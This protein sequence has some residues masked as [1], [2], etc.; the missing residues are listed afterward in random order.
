MRQIEYA[1]Q[2]RV[3]RLTTSSEFEERGLLMPIPLFSLEASDLATDSLGT[4]GGSA[5]HDL[6]VQ[7]RELVVVEADGDLSGHVPHCTDRVNQSVC[8]V[9]TFEPTT[10]RCRCGRNT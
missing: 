8:I 6:R 1:V 7:S 2:V 3:D 9:S 5:L 10:R 4:I